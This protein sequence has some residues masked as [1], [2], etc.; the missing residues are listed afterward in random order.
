M[1]PVRSQS[2]YVYVLRSKKTGSWYIGSTK[3]MKKRILS[4]NVGKNRSTKSGVPW[5]TIYC[6]IGLNRDDARAREK[7]LKS[8]QGRRYLKNRL[9]FFFS[10]DF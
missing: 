1:S 9:K 3:D 10:Y 6:E 7:Y 2:W 8:G 5:T 4:H